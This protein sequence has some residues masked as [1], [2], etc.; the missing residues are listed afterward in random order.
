MEGMAKAAEQ[1]R[2]LRG[3]RELRLAVPDARAAAVRRRVAAAV[4]CLRRG[5]EFEA[6]T[7]TERVSEFDAENAR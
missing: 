2:Q 3:L 6:L 1:I 4:G 5:S 7:W